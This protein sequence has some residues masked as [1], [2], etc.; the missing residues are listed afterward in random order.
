MPSAL[1]NG[2]RAFHFN[3]CCRTPC[4]SRKLHSHHP[5]YARRSSG[6]NVHMHPEFGGSMDMSRM[7]RWGQTEPS[8]ASSSWRSHVVRSNKNGLA[9]GATAFLAVNLFSSC[10]L[11]NRSA[12]TLMTQDRLSTAMRRRGLVRA[13]IMIHHPNHYEPL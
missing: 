1:V 6:G 3:M 13:Q 11:L 2:G 12:K 4:R 8:K 5:T 9:H 7:M 10:F